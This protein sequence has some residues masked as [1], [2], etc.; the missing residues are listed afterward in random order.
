MTARPQLSGKF[1]STPHTVE[2]VD[3]PVDYG[4]VL[5]YLG[6]PPNNGA[7]SNV[8]ELVD[9]WIEEA[10]SRAAPRAIYCVLPVIDKDKRRLRLRTAEGDIEFQGAIGEFLRASRAIAVFIST[11]GPHVER[12]ASELMRAGE[13]LPAMVVNAV[14]AERAEAAEAVV[15]EQLRGLAAPVGY[16]VTLPYS[17]G[18]CGM[19]LTEQKKIFSLLD[20]GAVGVTLTEQCLMRPLKSVS[21]L[22]GLGPASE[23]ELFGSPCDRCELHNCAMRR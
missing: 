8:K 15:I 14:G 2:R 17:P 16:G 21:G 20:S 11:A 10:A 23:V 4:E 12:L 5:R 22:I 19:K 7:S 9:P 3:S 6:Y 1:D 13:Q 18:Y